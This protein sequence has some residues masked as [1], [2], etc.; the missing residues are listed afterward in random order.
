MIYGLNNQYTE[1][2]ALNNFYSERRCRKVQE[3]AKKSPTGGYF[4]HQG[5][6]C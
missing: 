3:S 4:K 5:R 2:F 6:P 1:T